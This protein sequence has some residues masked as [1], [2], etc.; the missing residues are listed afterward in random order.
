[1]TLIEE[2]G[3][4]RSVSCSGSVAPVL[5]HMAELLPSC[6]ATE[7]LAGGVVAVRLFAEEEALMMGCT[8]ARRQEFGSIRSCA[9][10]A[11]RTLGVEPCAILRSPWP[12]YPGSAAPVWPSGISGSM[13]HCRG[14]HAA[15]V[16]WS[17]EVPAVGID[18]EPNLPL[19]EGVVGLIAV[20]REIEEMECH[21]RINSAVAWDR[22]VFSAKES[23][24]KAWWPL[25][26]SWLGFR[27]CV[28]DV[29][30][31]GTLEWSWGHGRHAIGRWGLRCL[32]GASLILTAVTLGAQAV[33][34][35]NCDG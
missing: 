8:E 4:C 10:T 27:D 15:A 5:A 35:G 28:V 32:N 18:A 1:M 19:P 25:N 17:R 33:E 20:P 24:F 2:I 16:A 26:E 23:L 6:V 21:G 3:A 9:R 34:E 7:E 30:V 11:L 31:G 12:C 29:H 13:T 22:V 14:Y